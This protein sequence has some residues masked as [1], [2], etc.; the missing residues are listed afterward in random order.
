MLCRV[1]RLHACRYVIN[2]SILDIIL[3]NKMA[4]RRTSKNKGNTN[5]NFPSMLLATLN[6]SNLA[7]YTI[8]LQ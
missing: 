6:D 3:L 1:F 8:M 2:V 5:H 4:S 7:H